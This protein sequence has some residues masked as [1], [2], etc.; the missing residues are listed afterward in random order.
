LNTLGSRVTIRVLSRLALSGL[1]LTGCAGPTATAK[2][3]L[4]EELAS[5]KAQVDELKRNQDAT[6]REAAMLVLDTRSVR[7][8][9]SQLTRRQEETDRLLQ[10]IKQSV[11]GVSAQVSKL[12]EPKAAP[13]PLPPPRLPAPSAG[14]SAEAL[15]KSA[16]AAYRAKDFYGVI[17]HLTE[18]FAQF[19]DHRLAESAQQLLGESYY[20]LQ[21]FE[22]ALG[23][24]LKLLERAPKGDKAPDALLKVGLCYRALGDAGEA[25]NAWERLIR[26]HPRSAEAK[27]AKTL[28]AEGSRP[29][30]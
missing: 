7:D 29:R 8:T 9:L 27:R 25:R 18:F 22:L 12:A 6:A 5:L 10:A 11:E 3:T 23:E 1:L 21:E 4:E 28:L 17:S 15:H 30:R 14:V 20:A 13:A 24:F 26:E 16:A 2:K 19:P